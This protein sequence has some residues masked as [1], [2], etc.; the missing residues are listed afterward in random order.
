MVS[1]W[2]MH[3]A[4]GIQKITP[5]LHLVCQSLQAAL[6]SHFSLASNRFIEVRDGKDLLGHAIRFPP[7]SLLLPKGQPRAVPHSV[8]SSGLSSLILNDSSG[9]AANSSLWEPIPQSNGLH[10]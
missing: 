8:F 4:Q 9:G 7:P 5:D 1:A 3:C 6:T 2:D 10:C